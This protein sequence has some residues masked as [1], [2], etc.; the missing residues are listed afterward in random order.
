MKTCLFTE[1]NLA[2]DLAENILTALV[3]L[4]HRKTLSFPL[5]FS[6]A[7]CQYIDIWNVQSAK[8]SFKLQTPEKPIMEPLLGAANIAQT[9]I[10]RSLLRKFWI[11]LNSSRSMANPIP[12]SN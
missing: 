1:I 6:S 3:K 4:P 5:V 8:A 12:D 10:S 2:E 7:V 11:Y 9:A